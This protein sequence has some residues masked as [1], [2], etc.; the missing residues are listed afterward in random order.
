[1][2]PSFLFLDF[3]LL[4]DCGEFPGVGL[5]ANAGRSSYPASINEESYVLKYIDIVDNNNAVTHAV[6]RTAKEEAVVRKRIAAQGF[7]GS[8]SHNIEPSSSF[9]EFRRIIKRQA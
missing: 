4:S 1:M 8:E 9:W 5:F 6:F 2:V 3:V 7:A